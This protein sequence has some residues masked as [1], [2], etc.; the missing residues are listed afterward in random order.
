ME[1]PLEAG[2]KPFTL[3]A[4]A[5]KDRGIGVG[6]TMAWSLPNEF[7]HFTSVPMPSADTMRLLA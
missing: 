1:A 4:A 2:K 3:I 7:H 6:G 5:T